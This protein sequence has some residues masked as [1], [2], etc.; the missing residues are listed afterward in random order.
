MKN[1]ENKIN[2][3]ENK[4]I[5][6][7]KHGLGN[8]LF[9]TAL[10]LWATRGNCSRLIFDVSWYD[11]IDE[12]NTSRE[13]LVPKIL[14][15]LNIPTISAADLTILR[16]LV[17]DMSQMKVDAYLES[18]RH[19]ADQTPV[20]IF[21]AGMNYRYVSEVIERMRVSF[22]QFEINISREDQDFF[23]NN[24]VVG[25]HV[26]LG[27]YLNTEIRSWIG[28]VDFKAQIR[29]TAKILQE[30]TCNRPV[31]FAIF[32]NGKV[33]HNFNREFISTENGGN[34]DEI[35]TLKLMSKCSWLITANS[36][37]S[38]FA[39]YLSDNLKGASLPK[40][41]TH[42]RE[43]LTYSLMAENMKIYKNDLI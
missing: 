5:I 31:K 27:D 33:D 40:K 19:V 10:G 22:G 34:Y 24:F 20:H 32:S 29:E 7:L 39:A 21:G 23:D 42:R 8:Q 36:T 26:R 4:V 13:I 38:I 41:Y 6:N 3:D 37:Y 1:L 16:P 35:S 15:S 9:Q 28:V 12:A 25:I 18:I 43:D 17:I 30:K 2:K 11:K 14:S